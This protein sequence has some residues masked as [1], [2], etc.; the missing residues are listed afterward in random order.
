ML[1]S[2]EEARLAFEMKIQSE[3]SLALL[4]FKRFVPLQARNRGGTKPP[5]PAELH[6]PSRRA[7]KESHPPSRRASKESHLPSSRASKQPHPPPPRAIEPA[8]PGIPGTIDMEES[9]EGE[10]ENPFATP[11]FK[12]TAR[13]PPG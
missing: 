5:P 8:P 6:P 7:S 13:P 10:I 4:T 3:A 2:A 12:M 1:K 11:N 9:E